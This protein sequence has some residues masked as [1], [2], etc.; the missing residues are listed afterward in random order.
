M[1][2]CKV[3]IKINLSDRIKRFYRKIKNLIFKLYFKFREKEKIEE[4]QKVKSN[5]VEVSTQTDDFEAV[6]IK[7]TM[8]DILYGNKRF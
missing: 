6:T 1:I 2:A 3:A 8:N 4:N 7:F 5:Q